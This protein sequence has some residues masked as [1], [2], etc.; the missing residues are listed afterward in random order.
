MTKLS[1][2]LID[3][4]SKLLSNIMDSNARIAIQKLS[5][6]RSNF[7]LEFGSFIKPSSIKEEDDSF[8]IE[9]VN[10]PSSSL[11]PR[12][13]F[14]DLQMKVEQIANNQKATEL[15]FIGLSDSIENKVV[16]FKASM[17]NYVAGI[18]DSLHR[19]LN[20]FKTD[21]EERFQNAKTQI[22]EGTERGG[23]EESSKES[24]DSPISENINP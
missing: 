11:I 3:E 16:T 1:L 18:D 23:N 21:M 24:K 14:I 5:Q 17:E 9:P 8:L 15:N 20:E 22:N 2:E 6:L 13:A 19:V 12:S 4:I 10:D 7:V